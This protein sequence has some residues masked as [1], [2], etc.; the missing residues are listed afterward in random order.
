[1]ACCSSRC[2]IFFILSL[3]LLATFER[4]VFDGLGQLWGLV[5]ID[6]L[7]IIF[8]IMAIIAVSRF[9]SKA[10]VVYAVWC[11]IWIALNTV[12]ILI[13]LKVDVFVTNQDMKA[14]NDYLNLGKGGVTWWSSHGIGCKNE[15]G[16]GCS[17]L[18]G[19]PGVVTD[20]LISYMFVEII[21]A[22]VQ[23]ALA[24]FGFGLAVYV[25]IAFG[26]EDDHFDFVGA[27]AFSNSGF[28]MHGRTGHMQLQ[29]VTA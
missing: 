10:V 1:M 21:H 18:T 7:N 6:G 27:D 29:P 23:I 2:S 11:V 5:I 8:V 25:A 16:T 22:G 13:Y 12:V 26:D 17:F 24:V 15:N 20:C 9:A 4:T 14:D 28:E 3:Q 19:C